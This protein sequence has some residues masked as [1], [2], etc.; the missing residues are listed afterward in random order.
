[1]SL[2][3][4]IDLPFSFDGRACSRLNRFFISQ[5][6]INKWNVLAQEIGHLNLK[7]LNCEPKNDFF[8][9]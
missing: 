4:T 9:K 1:M 7:N 5:S 8:F 2:L 3:S 6:L